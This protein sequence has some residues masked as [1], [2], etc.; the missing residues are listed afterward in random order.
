MSK[1]V[2][3]S[4]GSDGYKG[5]LFIRWWN[6]ARVCHDADRN[7]HLALSDEVVDDV[8]EA[9]ATIAAHIP[10]AIVKEHQCGRLGCVILGWDIDPDIA[11]CPGEHPGLAGVD[12]V[13]H[14]TLWNAR[15]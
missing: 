4:E 9:V 7:R 8:W 2:G 10:T 11:D 1:R 6:D 14:H 12:V 5:Q 15:L 3:S 13:M